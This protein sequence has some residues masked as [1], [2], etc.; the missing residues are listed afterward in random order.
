MT[1]QSRNAD[2]AT[3]RLFREWH[4]EATAFLYGIVRTAATLEEA[5]TFDGE[6]ALYLG[7]QWRLLRALER[8]GGA[9]SFTTRVTCSK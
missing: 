4:V 3:R 2:D 9:P 7:A 5:K 1:Q 6:P 8:C